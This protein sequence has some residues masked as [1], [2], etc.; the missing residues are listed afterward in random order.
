MLCLYLNRYFLSTNRT[1]HVEATQR[2]KMSVSV[3]NHAISR[4]LKV[5]SLVSLA[6]I[7][8]PP[9]LHLAAFLASVIMSYLKADVNTASA[10]NKQTKKNKET[11][12]AMKRET[13]KSPVYSHLVNQKL[14]AA[15]L[16]RNNSTDRKLNK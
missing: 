8:P 16:C 9:S 3:L 13:G 2:F 10:K 15:Y 5:S 12:I 7:T 4:Q 14:V 1:E 11:L 6:W